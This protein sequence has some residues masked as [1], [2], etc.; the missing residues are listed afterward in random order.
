MPPMGASML[1]H[2]AAYASLTFTVPARSCAATA[3]PLVAERLQ[4]L[5]LSP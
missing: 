1:P 3:R 2:A 5:A 4:T